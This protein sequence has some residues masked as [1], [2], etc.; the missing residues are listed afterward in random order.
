MTLSLVIGTIAVTSAGARTNASAVGADCVTASGA[1]I[2]CK[3]LA[4]K[5]LRLLG[6]RE[7]KIVRLLARLRDSTPPRTRRQPDGVQGIICRVFVGHCTEALHVARCESGFNV[8]ARNGQ[9][10]GIWQMGSFARAKYGHSWDAWGQSRSAYRYF[11][12]AGWS[13]WACKP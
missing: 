10:W 6:A 12:D 5:R 13:P 2:S 4:S 8:Y 7:R 1:P 3:A 9:Y 11:L